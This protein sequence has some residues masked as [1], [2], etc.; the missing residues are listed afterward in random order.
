MLANHVRNAAGKND[1]LLKWD[2]KQKPFFFFTIIL[3]LAAV[4][5]F[6]IS[7]GAFKII[8]SSSSTCCGFG[9]LYPS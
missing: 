5:Q 8:Y 2:M 3:H 4:K 6:D 9:I 1:V 7:Y